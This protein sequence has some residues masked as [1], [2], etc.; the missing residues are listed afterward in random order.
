MNDDFGKTQN[1]PISYRKI[2]NRRTF[3]PLQDTMNSVRVRESLGV[4][5]LH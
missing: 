5:K 1:F 4:Y 2:D 3:T